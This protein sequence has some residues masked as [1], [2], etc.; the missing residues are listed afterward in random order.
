MHQVVFTGRLLKG[1]DRATV[2]AEL[3]R[4]F[5][6]TPRQVEWFLRGKPIVVKS[7]EDAALAARYVDALTRAGLDCELRSDQPPSAPMAPPPEPPAAPPRQLSIPGVAV[8]EPVA[9]RRP[10][11]ATAAS[12]RRSP[13][14]GSVTQAITAQDRAPAFIAASPAAIARKAPAAQAL[15]GGLQILF[16]LGGAI[17]VGALAYALRLHWP[18]RAATPSAAS[19][20]VQRQESAAAGATEITGEAAPAQTPTTPE[21]LIVGRWQCV[22]A[23]SGRVVENEFRADGSYRSLTHGRS[24]AFQQIDQLDVLVEGRY[25]LEGDTVVLNLQHIPSREL[26]GG[27]ARVDEYLY[28]RIESLTADSLLWADARL[29][30]V[31]ESCLRSQSVVGRRP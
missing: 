11:P 13:T 19:P 17:L 26:F 10:G 30:E 14:L 25:W 3:Q 15:R 18:E 22:E 1:A 9:A 29:Q 27:S 31:R 21:A 2:Q 8:P 24:D 20:P 7:T 5:K 16:V 6:A 12:P 28:W 4:L 23:T